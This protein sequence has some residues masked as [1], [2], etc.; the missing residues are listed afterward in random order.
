M[1]KNKTPQPPFA[2]GG[3]IETIRHSLAHVLMQ[4]LTRLY[5]AIPGVGP[6][7][8]NGFYHDL[9]ANHQ[10]TDEDL[11][12]I[13]K[14]MKKI[15]KEDLEIKKKI[16]PIDAGIKFLKDKGYVYT[17]E[18]AEDLKAQGE[19]EI[20]FYEQGEFV[21]MCKGPH[22]GSTGEL[23]PDAF[24]LTRLAG[25]YWKGDEKN[26]MLQRVYGVAFEGKEELEK[27]LEMMKEAE[28]RDHKK[29]GKELD[30]FSFHPE[31]P[32]MPHWHEKGMVIW[33]ELEKFG[34]Q[35][36]KKY[37]SMEI[38][39]PQ[40]A[41]NSLWITSGHWDHFKDDM[42]IFDV[43]NETYCLKPMDCP[44]NINIYKTK[45]RSYKDLPIRYTEIG[46][47]FR[48]ERSG[49][50]NGLFR[51]REI[52]QDDSHI[53]LT[54]DQVEQEIVNLLNMV[55]EYYAALNIEPKYFFSTRPDDFMGE[56]KTWDKAESDLK[57][58]LE[59]QNIKYGL[60]EKD[61]AFYGPKID[62]NIK[63][64]FGRS[65]QVATIQL[66][67]QLPGRFDCKYIDKDGV[68]RTLAIIHAAIFGSFER[69]IGIL[70]EHYGGAFPL[71]L[72]PVQVKILPVSDKFI[73][74]AK[75][76]ADNLKKKD[77]RVEVDKRSESLGK[78]IRDAQIQ[79]TSYMIIVGE[80]EQSANKVRP[81]HRKEG[82]IGELKIEE[83]AA[84]LEKEIESK[85]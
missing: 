1:Q 33:N 51:V 23:N 68:E 67:F 26:K 59:S 28:K 19:T 27:H 73:D 12:N 62:V 10:I 77:I 53:F 6:F 52:T 42:F 7:I 41:K 78:K 17:V 61:G 3:N 31:S 72:S 30:L 46:R 9:E 50:L 39:T 57:K 49:Q 16:M 21:N 20:S 35:I 34:K 75:G 56:I 32:G 69:M 13:E 84:R 76:V 80:K 82:D 4:A 24:K 36:R 22:L 43:D 85:S 60:K 2:K 71:W 8:E 55:K 70:I 44:F 37:G 45:P 81:R 63:D 11:S 14:E 58:A 64:V 79:K 47:V 25:A 40:M 38:K 66:D 54:E 65:W 74:Y 15:I 18:L 83:F 29:L 48:N 5:G